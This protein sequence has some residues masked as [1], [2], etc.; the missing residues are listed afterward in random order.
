MKLSLALLLLFT[1][2]DLLAQDSASVQVITRSLPNKV[3]LRWAVDRPMAWKQANEYGFWVERG[4]ISRNGEAVVPIERKRLVTKPLKPKPLEEWEKWAQVDQHAA[5]LAQALY[6]DSFEVTPPGNQLG[7]VY[8]IND[9]LEQRFTFALIAAEQSYEASKLAGWALEDTTAIAGEKYVYSVS[10]VVPETN[11]WT[12]KNGTAF[13][14]PNDFGPLPR[15]V[16]LAALFSDGKVTLSWN[17]NLLQRIYT[18]YQVERSVDNSF[19]KPL[20]GVPIFSAQSSKESKEI[21]MFYIDSIPNNTTFY[22]RIK[23]RTAFGEIGPGSE[24]VK[25]NANA[26]LGYV[27][28]IYK[29][30]FPMDNRVVLGWEFKKEGNRL[31]DKFQLRKSDN[32]TGPYITVIDSIPLTAREIIYE[33]LERVNYFTLVAIGKNGKES[34]SYPSLVQP[35]DSI[36]PALPVGLFGIAD[37]MGIVK[38]GWIKNSEVDLGGYRI[39]RSLDSKTEFGEITKTIIRGE[40][41]LDTIPINN[42]N[43]KVYYKVLAEDQRYNRSEFSEVFML[44]IPDIIPPASPMLKN[45]R[46][47]TEGVKIDWIPS[48]SP[49]VATHIIYRKD[50]SIPEMPWEKLFESFSTNDS[51][52]TDTEL[53]GPNTYSYTLIA[54]DSGGLE[55]PPAK[56]IHIIWKGKMPKEGDIKLSGSVDRE[57]RHISLAWKVKDEQVLEYRL[58]RGKDGNRLKLYKTFDGNFKGFNDTALEINSDYTYGLQ[59][60][61]SGGRTSLVTTINLIY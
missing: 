9:E 48:S 51:S 6:G 2:Y 17:F 61:L 44:E 5:I 10:V 29:K 42:L 50:G 56:P 3:L 30:E 38:L 58:Y 27:P 53:L 32:I 26:D 7:A 22:Y 49:D 8:A 21:P 31:I 55:S 57:L 34:E 45:Y 43:R 39:Y 19:F 59:L 28:R 36:P 47:T 11:L 13:V 33:G 12:I 54:R 52:F 24:V 25:G 41:Y 15:P 46:V 23:G 16:G 40:I 60:I 20:N 1:S 14:D 37:T 35:V 18:N 4:T